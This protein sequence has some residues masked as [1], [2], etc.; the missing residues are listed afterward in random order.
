[1][2]RNRRY[3]WFNPVLQ[4]YVVAI[5]FLLVSIAC[6][7]FLIASFPRLMTGTPEERRRYF[8]V[9][10]GLILSMM[11]VIGSIWINSRH[12]YSHYRVIHLPLETAETIITMKFQENGINHDI[13]RNPHIDNPRS[14]VSGQII[15][16]SPEF[17]IMMIKPIREPCN[18]IYVKS[19]KGTKEEHEK[20]LGLI[21]SIVY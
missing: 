15:F 16:K 8:A 2:E 21:D 1:V 17:R 7:A 18:W 11:M 14:Q 20:L 12:R 13:I 4:G 3:S 5:G 6:C 10:V 19:Y 9:S